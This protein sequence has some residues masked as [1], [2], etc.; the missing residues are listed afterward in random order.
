MGRSLRVLNV[1]DSPRDAALIH[2][3][4]TRAGYELVSERVET[5]EAMRHA[6][7]TETWDVILT[8][9]S[10]P[11]FSALQAI[12]LLRDSGLD[13]P[14]IIISGTIGRQVVGEAMRAGA[15][16][17]LMK[18]DLSRLVPVI[19]RELEEVRNRQLRRR[20]ELE[21]ELELEL[22][23]ERQRSRRSA[24]ASPGRKH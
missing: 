15:H 18:D 21:L 24:E 1:E 22:E 3:H 4:L 14:I 11:Q 17:Y 6:M 10:L 13:I 8:D 19:E 23:V 20:G 12:V 16:D 9:Y 7:K 5:A 2:R